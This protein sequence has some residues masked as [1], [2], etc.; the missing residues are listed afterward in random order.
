MT[1]AARPTWSEAATQPP[2][3]PG[4][5]RRLRATFATGCTRDPHWRIGQLRAL[6]AMLADRE[7]EIT[8]AVEAD[9]GRSAFET[10]LTNN[11]PVRIEAG[12]ARRHLRRWMRPHRTPTP[13]AV[14]PGSSH[15]RHEPL[16]VVGIIGPWNYPINLTLSPLV[17]ALAAGNC[18]VIKPSEL[19]P[20]TADLLAGLL[21]EF[22]DADAVAVVTGGADEAREL[23]AQ[24]LDH[25]LFTGSPRV[26]ALVM[27]SAAPHLTPVTLELGGK[28]P[29]VVAADADLDVTARRIALG[30]IVNS[31]QTCIAPDYV[32]VDGRC[33][34]RWRIGC[35]AELAEFRA[36]LPGASRRVVNAQHAARLGEL[37]VDH[38]GAVLC[39]GGVDLDAP[40]VEPTIV[41]RP[42]SGVAADA[43]GDSSARCSRSSA[44][45]T[46]T[47]RCGTCAPAASRS[48]PTCFA[49]GADRKRAASRT[50]RP[51][52]SCVNHVMI[53]AAMPQL[54][55]GGVGTSGM[56]AYHGRWGFETFTHRKAVLHK[57]VRPDLSLIYPPYTALKEKVLRR[58]F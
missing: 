5:V 38:G 18:A 35:A 13:L 36:A 24:G 6:E 29:V 30:K 21:P 17:G 2:D 26:G 4:E 43:G 49:S 8:A 55:F 32:L 44:S 45:R 27:A 50:S 31:G 54:P 53:H 25:L 40:S 34:S 11:I 20:A 1:S 19:A 52:A 47:R 3:V 10:V 14:Q 51:A 12:Y 42:G 33:R 7:A 28:C 37:L 48:P 46:L 16:G 15:Y 23:I 39:G 57:T 56:G 58:L 9:L 22:L 41:R